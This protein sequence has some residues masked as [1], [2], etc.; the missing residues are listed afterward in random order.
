MTVG[1]V[2]FISILL[3]IYLVIVQ[4]VSR[5]QELMIFLQLRISLS[6]HV[7]EFDHKVGFLIIPYEFC[8]HVHESADLEIILD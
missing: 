2:L 7:V 5:L 4:F 6:Y 3:K 8:Y 1:L